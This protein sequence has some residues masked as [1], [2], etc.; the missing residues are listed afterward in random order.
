M[1][2]CRCPQ[3]PHFR[4]LPVRLLGIL[5]V[6]LS[7]LASTTLESPVRLGE[8]LVVLNREAPL[9]SESPTR[10][11][12]PLADDPSLPPGGGFS[13]D[14]A[15]RLQSRAFYNSV[16]QASAGTP[17]EWSGDVSICDAGTTSPQFR[18]DVLVRINY[19]RAMA[20]VPA[21][22]TLLEA[23]NN[24]AQQAALMMSANGALSHYPPTSWRCYSDAGFEAAGNSN[25]SLGDYGWD[26][27]FGQMQDNGPSNGPVGHRRW[28]LHPQTRQMGTGDVPGGESFRPANALWV[29]DNHTWDVRPPTRDPFVTWPPPGYVPYQVVFPRWSFSY[30]DA[31]F[32]TASVTMTVGTEEVS[33]AQEQ[34]V[35]GAGENTLVWVPEGRD[36]DLSRSSWDRP[37]GDTT[38]SVRVENVGIGASLETF[39][40]QVTV[41]DPTTRGIHEVIPTVWGPQ[42][43][44][45]NQAVTFSY[46]TIPFAIDHEAL[47]A[48]LR[49]F[50]GVEG[51]EQGPDLIV[52]E[53]DES[54]SLITT[55]TSASGA[56]SFHLAHPEPM[57]QAF[58][59][60]PTL[61]LTEFS[62]LRFAKRLGYAGS[63]QIARAQLLLGDGSLVDVF[64]QAGQDNRGELAFSTEIV[65]LSA[66]AD[67]VVQVR[68]AYDFAGG[69]YYPQTSAAVG[70]HVDDI[71]VTHASEVLDPEL[72]SIGN[73][74]TFEFQ[75]D[76]P[77][78]YMLL[79]RGIGWEGFPALDWGWAFRVR[80]E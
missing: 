26:A 7:A 2:D 38:Y 16:F 73:S 36:A 40:Y 6:T 60:T 51:A 56:A 58:T 5:S 78:Q 20:G 19:F 24:K 27:V 75:A 68:F 12:T 15:D 62:E 74:G 65:D 48:R 50:T 70:F 54:Y 34:P 13:I 11:I 55:Q 30:P 57:H 41:I 18:R 17:D 8:A 39:D 9:K 43:I 77:G 45:R 47:H 25:L 32:S 49:P 3:D 1:N 23:Y 71:E 14:P 80:A 63:A 44:A 52:D 66:Y 53:T 61:L 28:I 64:S 69:S 37:E 76:A 33:L 31:D 4:S 72:T 59:L 21:E 79:V 67:R 46:D 22:V 35:M 42:Y 10:R 29:L